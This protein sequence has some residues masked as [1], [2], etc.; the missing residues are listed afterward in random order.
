MN[1]IDL[2][3]SVL[4]KG[5]RKPKESWYPSEL[6]DCRRRMWFAWESFPRAKVPSGSRWKMLAGDAIHTAVQSLLLEDSQE[7]GAEY[8]VEV[9]VRTG[10]VQVPGLSRPMSGRMDLV[11]HSAEGKIGHELKTTYGRG[12]RD[13]RDNGPKA[14]ALWQGI[15]YLEIEALKAARGE[16]EGEPMKA[17][18]IMYFSRDDADRLLFDLTPSKM[19][20]GWLLS[21]QFGEKLRPIRVIRRAEWDEVVSRLRDVEEAGGSPPERDFLAAIKGGEVKEKFVKN[22]VTYTS[23]WQCRYCPYSALC[24][25]EVARSWPGPDNSEMFEIR[26][27]VSGVR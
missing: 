19:G 7:P 24:W 8:R 10:R 23:D 25:D 18:K 9:E 13:V 5:E 2:V 12:V 4:E 16:L 17:V 11:I 26:K 1:V 6:A 27:G 22:G 20:S 3:E 21:S 14:S 15:G